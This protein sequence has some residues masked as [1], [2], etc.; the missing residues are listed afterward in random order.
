MTAQPGQQKLTVIPLTLKDA[1]AVV[2]RLHRHHKRPQGH[3]WSHGVIDED[4]RWRGVAVVG[5]PVARFFD[6][7]FTVEVTRVAT[8]G[9]P[10]ACSALYG[11]A[12]QKAK[13]DHYRAITYTQDGE[14]GAS[15]RA[16]GWKPVAELSPRRGW[17]TPSR[18]RSDRGTD[19]VARILWEQRRKDAPPLPSISVLRDELR[20]EIECAVCPRMIPLTLT[21][22]RPRIYCSR[23]CQQRAYRYRLAA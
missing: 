13:V 6:D 2:D 14:S 18:R 3:K 22:G 11:A 17:D 16:A 1:C 21:R 19:G 10:N 9:T 8:D 7:G 5:R 15:L 4:R 20:D 23:A 12:W